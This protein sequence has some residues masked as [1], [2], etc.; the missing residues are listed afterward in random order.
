MNKTI[1]INLGGRNFFIEEAAYQ[2]LEAY[3]NG[4]KQHFAGYSG[5][6]EIVAD[7]ESRIAEKFGEKYNNAQAV[8]SVADIE[9]LI[10]ELGTVEDIAGEESKSEKTKDKTTGSFAHKRLMRDPDDKILAGV[11]S[12]IAAY[13]DVDPFIVRLIFGILVLAWGAI[14]PIYLLLWLIMPKAQSPTE[15]MQMRGEPLNLETISETIKERAEEMKERVNEVRTKKEWKHWSIWRALERVLVFIAKFIVKFTAV[16][17]IIALGVSIISMTV[18][19]VFAIF[20]STSPYLGLPV[21]S[22]T[23]NL[24]FYVLLIAGYLIALVPLQ[25]LLFLFISMFTGRK[26]FKAVAGFVLLG[27]WFL[28]LV[29]AAAIGGRYVPQYIEEI[30]NSPQLQTVNRTYDVKDFQKVD[31]TSY[32]KYKLVQGDH[33]AVTAR[34]WNMDLEKLDAKVEDG[35][36]TI[37][38]HGANNICI[39][40]FT[41]HPTVEITAPS[42]DAIKAENSSDVSSSGIT[43]TSTS[44]SLSN[45]SDA[46]IAYNVQD[47]KLNLSNSSDARLTGTAQS[48]TADLSNSSSLDASKL[49]AKQVEITTSNSSDARLNVIDL[50]KYEIYNSSDVFY[51]GHPQVIYSGSGTFRQE[52][53]PEQP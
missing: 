1:S 19:L 51:T 39:F 24:A 52:P 20:N 3:L 5:S 45:S 18:A 17:M 23:H 21:S 33:F 8:I 53:M 7:M 27:V 32:V 4:I 29:I 15:K 43:G 41:G 14:I 36:L 40:C 10:A 13:F 11:C 46:D 50:L 6:T 31:L 48:I 9:S 42:F 38:R 44:L 2:K 37:G 30:K 12:G 35:T 49:V 16:C 26:S 25:F 47:L 28:A 22:L 34:G